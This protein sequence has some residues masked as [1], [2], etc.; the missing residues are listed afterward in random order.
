MESPNRNDDIFASL[1]LPMDNSSKGVEQ[2][3]RRREASSVVMPS[4]DRLLLVIGS[5]FIITLILGGVFVVWWLGELDEERRVAAAD[6]ELN[7]SIQ[8]ANDW[9]ETPAL[10]EYTQIE[11]R[12]KKALA[13]TKVTNPSSGEQ[14]LEEIRGLYSTSYR[15]EQADKL[16]FSAVE[17]L[18]AGKLSD[19]STILRQY[20][21]NTYA[22]KKEDAGLL[23]EQILVCQSEP[24]ALAKL[25]AL[26][27]AEFEHAKRSF[28]IPND[29]S[30][31]ELLLATRAETVRKALSDA[32]KQREITKQKLDE[33]MR[34]K[35]EEDAEKARLARLET[36]RRNAEAKIAAQKA[37]N[38][39]DVLDTNRPN[40]YVIVRPGTWGSGDW[41]K[42]TVTVQN[43]TLNTISATLT[44]SNSVMGE[45]FVP[46]LMLNIPPRGTKQDDAHYSIR[47]LQQELFDISKYTLN[48]E[49]TGL[50]A[51]T[52]FFYSVPQSVFHKFSKPTGAARLITVES[53]RRQLGVGY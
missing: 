50:E 8:A 4:S 1:D 41:N 43:N 26:S 35:A 16:Y 18:E 31:N 25:V 30:L 2:S 15:S 24:D 29:V 39:K 48:T 11:N 49:V 23:I 7:G 13:N 40:V 53:L 45:L 22:T 6:T 34:R 3:V 5:G 9:A 42:I 47:A 27:D 14:K 10:K 12:L 32:S 44:A 38:A 51:G 46:A 19:A 37:E 36:N 33:A 28:V 17:Y 20:V 21:E 52:Q